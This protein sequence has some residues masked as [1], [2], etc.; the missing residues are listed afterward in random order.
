MSDFNIKINLVKI[1]GAAVSTLSSKSGITKKC[2]VLPIEDA[3]LYEG[4]KGIYLNL[5]AYVL[6]SRANK[7]TH[8]IKQRFSEKVLSALSKEQ[9]RAIPIIGDLREFKYDECFF[10]NSQEIQESDDL[11]W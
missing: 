9:K 6:S 7:Q 3:D 4:E 10:P 11:P 1:K 8:I 2:V 5:S